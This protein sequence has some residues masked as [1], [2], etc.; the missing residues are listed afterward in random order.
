MTLATSKNL[1][2]LGIGTLLAAFGAAIV[3]F[4]S[5]G[6]AAINWEVLIGGIVLGVGQ[7]LAKGA[8]STGGTVN[9]A[10]VPVVDP[11][12]PTPTP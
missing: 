7:I 11:S 10:G 8:A 3:Q 1:T 9:A 4:A 6:I 5:G 12:P 2:I